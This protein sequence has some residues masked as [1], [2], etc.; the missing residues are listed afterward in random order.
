MPLLMCELYNFC[1]MVNQVTY[2]L[3]GI[4]C[5]LNQDNHMIIVTII[6]M[7]NSSSLEIKCIIQQFNSFCN[8]QTLMVFHHC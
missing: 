2:T 4:L 6:N 1:L 7:I 3:P 5:I 8:T